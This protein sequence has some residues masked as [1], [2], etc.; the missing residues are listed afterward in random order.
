MKTLSVNSLIVSVA[1]VLT[2][3]ATSKTMTLPSGQIGQSIRCDGAMLTIEAC[4]EKAAEVCPGGYEVINT[5]QL[6]GQMS[7]SGFSASPAGYGRGSYASGYSA[8]MPYI[9]K[10]MLIRCKSGIDTLSPM[11]AASSIQVGKE[12]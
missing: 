4:Y 3:C 12:R 5:D 9:Q 11:S 7:G 2:G 8:S 6:T 1:A 10:G